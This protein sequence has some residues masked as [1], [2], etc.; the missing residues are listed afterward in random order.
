MKEERE[1]EKKEFR[2]SLCYDCEFCDVYWCDYFD[3]ELKKYV[4]KEDGCKGFR[5]ESE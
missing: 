5:R 4:K 1:Q 2:E 3:T